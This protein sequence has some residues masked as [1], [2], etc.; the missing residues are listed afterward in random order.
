MNSKLILPVAIIIA[1]ILIAGTI[2]YT[3]SSSDKIEGLISAQEASDKVI[4]L[5]NDNFIQGEQ[6]AEII[7]TTEEHGVYKVKFSVQGQE[8]DWK[9]SKNGKLV[10]PETIDLEEFESENTEKE[11][12]LGDFEVTGNELCSEDGKPIVYFFGSETCP[13]CKWEHPVMQKVVTQFTDYISFHDNMD[14]QNDLE[15]FSQYSAE[16]YVPATLIGCK[17]FRVGSG[18]SVGEEQNIA[19]LTALICSLTGGQPGEICSGVQELIDNI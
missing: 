19:H 18:E 10:F 4:N 3:N 15:I 17:Y 7:E 8:L 13:H 11:K 14:S 1:G 6:V 5:I 2:V 16:G 9:I 12:T